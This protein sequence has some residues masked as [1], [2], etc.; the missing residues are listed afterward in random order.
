MRCMAQWDDMK[1]K[2]IL[3]TGASGFV[4]RP[5]VAALLRAGYVVRAVTRR[6]VSLPDSVEAAIIPDLK[7]PIDWNPILQG[8]YIVV[9]LAGLA[10]SKIPENT[11]S[12]FDQINHIDTAR[13]A[14]LLRSLDLSSSMARIPKETCRCS[15]NSRGRPFHSRSR[16]SRVGGHCLQSIISFL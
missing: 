14:C 11:N 13:R 4:G 12:E 16:A 9:H 1:T 8:V 7:N 2:R 3:V 5:L 6:Q 15:F 10:H